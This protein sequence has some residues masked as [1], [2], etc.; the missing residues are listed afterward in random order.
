MSVSADAEPRPGFL[1]DR[2]S[3]LLRRGFGRRM[4]IKWVGLTGVR[5]LVLCQVPL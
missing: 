5:R 1:T 4:R 2:L 3:P